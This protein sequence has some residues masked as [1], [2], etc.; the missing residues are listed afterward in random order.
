MA[1][2]L[3]GRLVMLLAELGDFANRCDKTGCAW[4]TAGAKGWQNLAE[5]QGI[6]DAGEVERL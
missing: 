3:V 2:T 5:F 4:P 6:R 1:P